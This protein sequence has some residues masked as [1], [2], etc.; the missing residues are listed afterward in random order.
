MKHNSTVTTDTNKE[1]KS[2]SISEKSAMDWFK[3]LLLLAISLPVIVIVAAIS[4]DHIGLNNTGQLGDTLGGLAGPFV[5]LIA[6]L[7][8]YLSFLQQKKANTIQINAL[9]DEKKLRESENIERDK[10]INFNLVNTEL[11]RL[12][13][14]F[15]NYHLS[16]GSTN[17]DNIGLTKGAGTLYRYLQNHEINRAT[18]TLTYDTGISSFYKEIFDKSQEFIDY[19]IAVGQLNEI[20]NTFSTITKSLN[21][22]EYQYTFLQNKTKSMCNIY[23]LPLFKILVIKFKEFTNIN[24]NEIVEITPNICDNTNCIRITVNRSTGKIDHYEYHD[25]RED[26]FPLFIH[27]FIIYSLEIF[28]N[29]SVDVNAVIRKD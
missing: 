23:I 20:I 1:G 15:N 13:D 27:M 29:I 22:N 12:S 26:G 6:A 21:L 3:I 17:Q 24:K 28:A 16:F 19:I 25:R 10:Q 4:T 8:V 14:Y 7:L 9:Q 2:D 18:D 11:N 5:N